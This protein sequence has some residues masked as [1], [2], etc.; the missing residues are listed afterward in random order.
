MNYR[1]EF[2]AGNFA[3]VFKHVA[4]VRILAYLTCKETPLRYLDTHA[5]VGRYDL[6]SDAAGRTGEWRGGIGR[7]VD[8]DMPETVA[9]LMR[10]Y[11]ELAGLT[12]QERTT[13]LGSPL[14]A[15]RLLR[16]QDRLVLCEL[17]PKDAIALE[18]TIGRDRR[19][20]VL[21]TDG[22]H[23]L[24]AQ[25]PPKERRG[26]VLIDPPFESPLE[27]ERLA[28][29]VVAAHRKWPTGAY[30][31]WY[32]LK[33][34]TAA[35]SFVEQIAAAGVSRLLRVEMQVEGFQA[36]RPLGGSGLLAINPPHVFEAEMQI[37]C[38]W[39]L[40]RLARG[41]GAAWRMESLA[42]E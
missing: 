38:P 6:A 29:A 33:Y 14:L 3:D 10:P 41:P 5:G 24:N 27:F 31:I 25:I 15:Q 22:Y 12:G 7:L 11:I 19:V 13:Y 40:S 8:A 17:H 4:L 16:S 30:L 23:A 37:L 9:A 35:Q 21:G 32:P 28:S 39:L 20:Q 42:G 34:P 1:H 36:D 26:L 18:R 2:H